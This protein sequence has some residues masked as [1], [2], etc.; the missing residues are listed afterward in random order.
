MKS[1]AKRAK[2]CPKWGKIGGGECKHKFFFSYTTTV[3]VILL[4]SIKN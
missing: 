4:N 3:Y 2:S 1:E